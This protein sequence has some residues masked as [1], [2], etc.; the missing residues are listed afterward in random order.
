[1]KITIISFDYFDFDKNIM[2][3]LQKKGIEA[4]HID[5]SKFKYRYKSLGEKVK[6]FFSKLL[7]G[8][9][10]KRVHMEAFVLRELEQ[11]GKQDQILVIRPDRISRKTHEIIKT[12]PFNGPEIIEKHKN[13]NKTIPCVFVRQHQ[14]VFHQ[15]SGKRIV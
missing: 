15:T 9:N 8:T 1:M 7:L 5:I 13:Q 14:P 6:N 3:A 10:V 11:W 4:H 2:E 12:F